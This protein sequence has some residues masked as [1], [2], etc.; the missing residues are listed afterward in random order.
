MQ[1]FVWFIGTVVD[2]IDPDKGGKVRVRII[3]E[4]FDK[5]ETGDLIWANIMMPATN[6]S[7]DGQGWSPTG[8]AGQ[9]C[10]WLLPRRRGQSTADGDGNFPYSQACI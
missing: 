6:A 8:I 3:N 4:H 1:N 5:I 10:L 7:Y 9:L 2:N